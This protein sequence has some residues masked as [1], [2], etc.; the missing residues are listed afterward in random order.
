M[1]HNMSTHITQMTHYA[2][3]VALVLLA[4]GCCPYHVGCLGRLPR[5]ASPSAFVSL[6]QQRSLK[7][8]SRLLLSRLGAYEKL[9]SYGVPCSG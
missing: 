3:D 6:E 9:N 5:V 8:T 2:W 1:N 7:G 4:S